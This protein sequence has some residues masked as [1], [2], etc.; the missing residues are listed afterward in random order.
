[1]VTTTQKAATITWCI[2]NTIVLLFCLR[3]KQCNEDKQYNDYYYKLL[4]F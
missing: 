3:I 1:M 2:I 4:T